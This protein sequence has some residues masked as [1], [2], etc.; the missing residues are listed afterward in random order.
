MRTF[1]TVFVRTR[2]CVSDKNHASFVSLFSSFT[3][4][5]FV[6]SFVHASLRARTMLA[7]FACERGVTRRA[8]GGAR[9]VRDGRIRSDR[10][11]F[12]RK[13]YPTIIVFKCIKMR[14]M[15]KIT[16]TG[17]P[18]SRCLGHLGSVAERRRAN[19]RAPNRTEPNRAS[20]LYEGRTRENEM[21]AVSTTRVIVAAANTP[22][23]G[24]RKVSAKKPAGKV[25][26]VDRRA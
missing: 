10:W 23:G 4:R 25:R 5:S 13:T 7:C 21:L 3:S 1:L 18:N 9:A 6:R 16:P 15:C 19:A 11:G 17:F 22:R 8:R 20:S 12:I 2:P 14:H 24:T 26:F